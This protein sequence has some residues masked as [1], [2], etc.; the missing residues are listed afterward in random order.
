MAQKTIYIKDEDVA[1]W[2]EV[3]QI[4]KKEN[5]SMS[6]LIIPYLMTRTKREREKRSK[7]LDAIEFLDI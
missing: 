2:N 3:K 1:V 5:S 7:S 4:L 6:D